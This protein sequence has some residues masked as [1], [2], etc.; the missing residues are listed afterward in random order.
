[1][2]QAI[3]E[4]EL[5]FDRPP[6]H[7]AKAPG[8]IN[9]IGDH[10]DYNDGIVLPMAIDRQIVSVAASNAKNEFQVYLPDQD[11]FFSTSRLQPKQ[12]D[13]DWAKY[14]LG[15][16]DQIERAGHE[17]P[18]FQ[19]VI[20]TNLP[21]GAGLSSSAALE[22]STAT[23][24]EQISGFSL[25]AMEKARLCQRAEHEAAGVPCGLMDQIS[26]TLCQEDAVL[27]LDCQTDTIRHLPF[28][29]D[30]L[31]LLITNSMVRHSLADGTYATRRK[32][33]EQCASL[34]GINSWRDI[35]PEQFQS[36]AGNLPTNLAKRGRHIVTEIW[37]TGQAS[38][39]IKSERWERL[40]KLMAESHASLRDQFEVS[41]PELDLLVDF[42]CELPGVLG[43]RMTGAGFGGC[44]ISLIEL[45]ERPFLE[46]AITRKFHAATGM[47]PE[48]F[49]S[50]PSR[51][52]LGIPL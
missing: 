9:L 22:I 42:T 8:R 5:K 34:I 43:S 28:S 24:V 3:R 46:R 27:E 41:C 13:P 21:I 25:P 37:R 52:A 19:S 12:T 51:G 30:G 49:L 17:V 47:N 6:E 20:V 18:P 10:I 26:V 33:C 38:C 40:G 11:E 29:P 32:E 14:I 44:T 45:S 1:M 31:G 16:L 2:E 23:L 50:A 7:A 35:N 48:I 15:V 39:A 36:V 4:F